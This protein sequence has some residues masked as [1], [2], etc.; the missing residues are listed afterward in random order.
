[1]HIYIYIYI[2]DIIYIRLHTYCDCIVWIT[3]SKMIK[4]MMPYILI[5]RIASHDR[6]KKARPIEEVLRSK[7]LG[8][9]LMVFIG[10]EKPHSKS[11][12]DAHLTTGNTTRII[13]EVTLW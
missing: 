7:K 11:Y 3:P 4:K 13:S 1:M 10:C 12:S 6:I 2:H 9:A 8:A 5:I